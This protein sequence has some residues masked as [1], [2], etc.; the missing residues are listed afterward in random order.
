MFVLNFTLIF[1]S[2]FQDRYTTVQKAS[3]LYLKYINVTNNL[4]ECYENILMP[5]KRI[6][7]RKLVDNCIGRVLELKHELV[8]LEFSEFTFLDDKL[9]SMQMIPVNILYIIIMLDKF[10]RVYDK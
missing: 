6:L 5:Q 10:S 7:L 1:F 9:L 8:A 4:I 3:T 2:F